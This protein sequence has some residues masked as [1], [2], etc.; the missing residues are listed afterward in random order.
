MILRPEEVEVG[1]VEELAA[2]T[3]VFGVGRM[4]RFLQELATREPIDR[5]GLD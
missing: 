2:F 5:A 3:A 1:S 4:P